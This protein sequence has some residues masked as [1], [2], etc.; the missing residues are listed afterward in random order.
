MK[1]RV[2]LVGVGPD[3]ESRHRPA[4]KS[5]S[6]RFDVRAVC[7]EVAVRA[8][9][10]A[11]EFGA[12][13]VDGFRALSARDDI[14]AVLMFS[15]DWY[16]TLPIFAACDNGKAIY[17]AGA[18]DMDPDMARQ[19][20]SRVEE[21]GIAFVAEF[22]R[23][24]APATLRLKELIATRLGPPKLLFCHRRH[25]YDVRGT[26]DNKWTQSMRELMELV[27][28]CRYTVGIDP[29]SVVGIRHQHGFAD[30]YQMFSLDFSSSGSVGTG[31]IAQ[32]SCSNYFLRDWPD[33]FSFR[34]P[35]ELQVCC[36]KGVA[37]VDLPSSLVW[38]DEAGQH[39]ESL[40]ADRPVGEQLLT[41]FHRAV[42]SLVR[43]TT[44]LD[45]TYT[46]LNI[47]LAARTSCEEGRRVELD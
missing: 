9:Q 11:S 22:P 31:P 43:R 14:D 47:V 26:E 15:P 33:A 40:E 17:C 35:A 46:A 27:D 2:G 24:C 34:P 19:V 29:S 16:G 23:R 45:D 13:A 42:T 25:E 32:I 12:E 18:M 44:D 5:L 28:W 30:D 37:F 3:W 20:R 39:R 21:S 1:L 8:E 36:E 6:D 38:F 10:V 7:S 4:L 41:Q